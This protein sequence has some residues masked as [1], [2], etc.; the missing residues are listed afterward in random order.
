VSIEKRSLVLHYDEAE[1]QVGEGI[2]SMFDSFAA[3]KTGI[4]DYARE[5]N[6]DI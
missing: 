4:R 3:R 5:K 2:F 1:R 6:K